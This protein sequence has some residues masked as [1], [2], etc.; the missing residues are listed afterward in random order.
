MSLYKDDN[1]S[2]KHVFSHWQSWGDYYEGTDIGD[3]VVMC[4]LK[5]ASYEWKND[6]NNPDWQNFRG[7]GKLCKDCLREV[8][9]KI[10]Y[11][12]NQLT[13]LEAIE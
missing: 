11:Y 1:N 8:K 6:Y 7:K 9:R 5:M 2:K 4:G 3:D 13:K 12:K 10:D